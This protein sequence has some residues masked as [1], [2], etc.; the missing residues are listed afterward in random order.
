MAVLFAGFVLINWMEYR[1]TT[2]RCFTSRS[3]ASFEFWDIFKMAAGV[4]V[5]YIG[6]ACVKR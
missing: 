6:G 5:A 4:F 2:L 1:F 3:W